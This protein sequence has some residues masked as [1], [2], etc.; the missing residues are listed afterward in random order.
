MAQRRQI[1]AT[2]KHTTKLPPITGNCLPSENT[3]QK[4]GGGKFPSHYL[5]LPG[6]NGRS[7]VQCESPLAFREREENEQIFLIIDEKSLRPLHQVASNSTERANHKMDPMRGLNKQDNGSMHSGR[8]SKDNISF[9]DFKTALFP[10][11]GLQRQVHSLQRR[12]KPG[13]LYQNCNAKM[14]YEELL[15]LNENAYE[16]TSPTERDEKWMEIKDFNGQKINSHE[17]KDRDITPCNVFFKA[18]KVKIK[19]A[20]KNNSPR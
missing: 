9:K 3:F 13:R 4:Y 15:L 16:E 8:T 6:I 5:R 17:T 1:N 19:N 14:P 10:K 18:R 11:K 2:L 20:V 12:M 7:P